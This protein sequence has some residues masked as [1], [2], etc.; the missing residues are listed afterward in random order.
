VRPAGK[1]VVEYHGSLAL[2]TRKSSLGVMVRA[3]RAMGASFHL[4]V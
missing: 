2:W 1:P 4:R 3:H